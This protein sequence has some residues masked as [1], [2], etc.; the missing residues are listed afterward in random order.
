MTAI[1]VFEELVEVPCIGG[2]WVGSPPLRGEP[3]WRPPGV[4]RRVVVGD[5]SKRRSDPL[6]SGVMGATDDPALLRGCPEKGGAMEK[7]SVSLLTC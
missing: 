6:A 7:L 1:G 2:N 4:T 3:G 5:D